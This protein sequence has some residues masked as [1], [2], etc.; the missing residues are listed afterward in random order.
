MRMNNHLMEV[1]KK[2]FQI[3]KTTTT[4]TTATTFR[5]SQ[6]NIWI[7]CLQKI[8]I[9]NSL[10]LAMMLQALSYGV[11]DKQIAGLGY[12]PDRKGTRPIAF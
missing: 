9:Q 12:L 1:Y 7:T 10:W 11:E 8:T 2:T 3:V 4:C 5:C 6:D